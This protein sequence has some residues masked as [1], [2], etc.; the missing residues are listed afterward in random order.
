MIALETRLL[1]RIGAVFRTVSF[2]AKNGRTNPPLRSA[3]KLQIPNYMFHYIHVVRRFCCIVCYYMILFRSCTNAAPK[4]WLPPSEQKRPALGRSLFGCPF[5][6]DNWMMPDWWNSL[7]ND[8]ATL[9][10]WLLPQQMDAIGSWHLFFDPTYLV[11]IF[12]STARV[13]WFVDLFVLQTAHL[14]P[15]SSIKRKPA[16]ECGWTSVIL[17]KIYA[18]NG[19][20]V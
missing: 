6:K 11:P 15:Q 1:K 12:R 7:L 20:A 13:A 14:N 16:D 8:P 2:P 10:V 19:N 5:T 4:I 9:E 3:P 18:W 17:S